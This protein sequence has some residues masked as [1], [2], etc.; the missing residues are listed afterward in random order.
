MLIKILLLV[1]VILTLLFFIRG[2]HT[3]R[4]QASKKLAFFAF[5]LVNVYAVL[6]P[7]DLTAVARLVGVGR[8]A[9]LL[10]Y[11]LVVAFIFGGLN[12]YLKLR[13]MERRFTDL[14]RAVAINEAEQFNRERGLLD[15]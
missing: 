11:M 4:M 8:G 1:A 7:D 14:S 10:L 15:E 12:V 9:D 2:E 13:E 6:R 5:V 3:L